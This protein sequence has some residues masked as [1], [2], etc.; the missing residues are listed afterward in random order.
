MAANVKLKRQN[1]ARRIRNSVFIQ[2][3]RDTKEF[4]QPNCSQPVQEGGSKD[5]AMEES[6]DTL[7]FH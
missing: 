3:E 1:K 5:Y 6:S 4:E 7:E 2:N